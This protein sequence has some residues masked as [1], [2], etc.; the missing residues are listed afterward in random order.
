MWPQVSS[1]QKKSCLNTS[2]RAVSQVNGVK[3]PSQEG[4]DVVRQPAGW[5]FRPRRWL[6]MSTDIWINCQVQAS[7]IQWIKWNMAWIDSCLFF[8]EPT[9]YYDED[10]ILLTFFQRFFFFFNWEVQYCI[11]YVAATGISAFFVQTCE[12][13]HSVSVGGITYSLRNP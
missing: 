13:G 1:V 9:E 10:L 7:H 3:I 6:L 12:W 11:C 8:V 2:K 5:F 4:F